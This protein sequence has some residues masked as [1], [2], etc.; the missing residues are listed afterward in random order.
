MESK[1]DVPM[2]APQ[3]CRLVIAVVAFGA[4]LCGFAA[5]YIRLKLANVPPPPAPL[6]LAN[7]EEAS[8]R[9]S[10]ESFRRSHKSIPQTE[11][12]HILDGQFAMVTA[13]EAI[14]ARLKEAFTVITGAQLGFASGAQRFAMENPDWE[15][16]YQGRRV[17]SYRRLLFAG[18]SDNKWFIHY[19]SG[20]GCG[21]P[22]RYYVVVFDTDEQNKVRFLWG[23][24]GPEGAAGL[25]DLRRGIATGRFTDNLSCAW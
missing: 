10:Q 1:Y 12:Q 9:R 4:V 14:P 8:I 23:G 24:I 22:G 13:T 3:R 25:D 7:A 5:H 2:G 15:P 17:M 19:L 21:T 20:I 11:K 6:T 18:L 16:P